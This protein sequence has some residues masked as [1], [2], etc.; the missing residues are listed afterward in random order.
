MPQFAEIPV[1]SSLH[2]KMLLFNDQDTLSRRGCMAYM[3]N[4]IGDAGNKDV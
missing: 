1:V 3:L 2:S 4:P